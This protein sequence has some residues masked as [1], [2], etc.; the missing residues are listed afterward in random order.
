MN[1][2]SAM[3]ETRV[4]RGFV[5]VKGGQ[6][7]YRSSGI[8]EGVPLILM[9]PSPGSGLML[10]PLLKAM[11]TKQWTIALDTR[12]NGDSDPL[13]GTPEIADF[14]RA[15]WEA[16]DALGIASCF[17][18]GTHTGASIATEASIQQPERVR[19][20]II[21]NMGLWSEQKKEQHLARNA[22]VV[23][24][25]M[26]GSQFNWAWHYCRDQYLFSPWYERMDANRRHIDLPSPEVLHDFVVEVLKALGTY[27]MS[28]S[29]AARY[30]KRERLPLVTVPTMVSSNDR[31]PLKR[32]LDELH[33]L[34][35]GSVKTFVGDLETDEGAATAAEVYDR[36]LVD[37]R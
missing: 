4:K 29:A 5:N 17:L 24:P 21:D 37:A 3:V 14:A 7:H 36:F 32:Y 10:M 34:V 1:G 18:L 28:Y 26:I 22:P 15:A 9:H 23:E 8:E 19:R 2:S 20:L 27:H 33:D 35:P 12:G 16:I 13:P 30:A 25:D 11:G 31:D 6:V